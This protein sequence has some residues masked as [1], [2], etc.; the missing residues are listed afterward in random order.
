MTGESS[1]LGKKLIDRINEENILS[2]IRDKP[3]SNKKNIDHILFID[4]DIDNKIKEFK[5]NVFLNI[6][7]CS[8]LN[9]NCIENYKSI[10]DFN[11]G[12]SA[13]LV[14][15]AVTSGVTKIIN[16]TS[17]WAYMAGEKKIPDCFNFYSFTKY[18]LDKYI[19]SKCKSSYCKG[20]SL[21]LY[22]NFDLYDP[23]KKIFN[24]FYESLNKNLEI[25]FSPG[26]QI[27]N[28]SRMEEVADALKYCLFNDIS[29]EEFNYF[30]ISGQEI[31]LIELA[32]SISQ[33]VNKD[34]SKLRFGKLSYRPGEIMKPKYFFKELPFIG[35]R[36]IPIIKSIE[37]EI[38]RK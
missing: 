16:I 8:R 2:I 12:T 23:R 17:N 33:I 36:K 29:T 19:A 14:D 31:S 30:Q 27:V 7:S 32:K 38:F 34:F 3:D 4:K 5:P 10:V 28:L 22:D 1:F 24:L 11:I 18:A 35:E 6:A 13:Y 21:V 25:D 9:S 20:I 37:R 26:H 15:L